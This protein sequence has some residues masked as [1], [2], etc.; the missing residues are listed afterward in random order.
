MLL[1]IGFFIFM[2]SI[3]F[4]IMWFD[5][6]RARKIVT[7]RISEGMMF[8]IAVVFGGVGIYIGMYLF[9]HKTKKWYFIVGIPFIIV[10]NIAFLLFIYCLVN[11]N[12]IL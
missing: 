7:Q 12:F 10:Q 6:S 5:K 8:F 2:N 11:N 4:L 9:R 3:A 1:L